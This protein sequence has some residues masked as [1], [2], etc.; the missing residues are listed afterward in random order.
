MQ[1]LPKP[2][3][4]L[5]S[6][7][8]AMT[9]KAGSLEGAGQTIIQFANLA[10]DQDQ[11]VRLSKLIGACGKAGTDLAPL[12][13]FKLA[14]LSNGTSDFLGPALVGA[15][16]RY[17]LAVDCF[18]APYGQV[19]QSALNPEAPLYSAEPDAILIAL[20]HHALTLDGALGQ[21]DAAERVVADVLDLYASIRAALQA[22]SKAILI[23][24]T[25][26]RPPET[27]FGSLDFTLPGTTRTLL[28]AINRGL[29]NMLSGSKDLLLDIAGLAETVGL[30]NWHDPSLWNMA[31]IPFNDAYVPLYCDHVWR[32][33][34]AVQGKSRRALVL[35][36]DN[37]V[38]GGVIG[39]DGLEGIKCAQGDATGEAHLSVQKTA[40]D[41]RSR[42]IVLAVSSKNTDDVAR[43]PFKA[44][45]E[46]LL[47]EDHIAVFQANWNDKASNIKAIA[48]QLSLGLAS[49]VFLDDNP[50]ERNL[51][52]TMLP[53]VAAP[54]LPRDPAHYS[55][56]LLAS[57]YFDAVHAS[58]EDFKRATFYQ[59]NAR[60]VELQKSTGNLDD[61]L[62]SL[63]MKIY[64]RPF[65]STGRARISQLINKSNQFNLT[66]RRYTE[67]DVEL[68]END[69][70][71][72]HQQI[73][74][75]DAFGDNGMISVVICRP[76]DSGTWEIDTWL[77]SCR[78][79]SRRVEDAVL[80]E[81]VRA[82]RAAG[83][84]RLIGV[85]KP[86]ARNDIVK[87]HY[88]K[89]GFTLD[90]EEASG[91]TVWTLDI[92]R[93]TEPKLP[94]TINRDAS[95]LHASGTYSPELA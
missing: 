76:K 58:E 84:Q 3:P 17:G 66:T 23:F 71:T 35:D 12:K 26:A 63:D 45:P 59:D 95:P 72:F 5:T 14:V 67:A 85:F 33:I 68:I 47:R 2:D 92:A 57:G 93:Y 56:T 74:L 69:S 64:F 15:A 60:R 39:D 16:A 44:H 61:Y 22:H 77:M 83:V 53:E 50:M 34:A 18:L 75:T 65:D 79:L 51:V 13:P 25:I 11:L 43:G 90:H 19:V 88:K 70:A 89:L 27:L 32:V 1:W 21:A 28:E 41:L 24:Q 10:L 91:E 80:A 9:A 6:K 31:K 46:M 54:E 20:D 86:S 49:F 36:L 30:A 62:A 52:R 29:A 38:W 81:I 40:L 87:D 7:V 55:R 73:R 42:G 78:V 8:R 37:T 4:D 94:M 82:A 48:D